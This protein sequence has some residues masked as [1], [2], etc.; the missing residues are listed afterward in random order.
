MKNDAHLK[1]LKIFLKFLHAESNIF[2]FALEFA[3]RNWRKFRIFKTLIKN[4][5]VFE[6]RNTIVLLDLYMLCYVFL[7]FC[8]EEDR[9]G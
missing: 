6:Y 4:N 7:I 5:Q 9:L 3:T 1:E 2:S 8:Q